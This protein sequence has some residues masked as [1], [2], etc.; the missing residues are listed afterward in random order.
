MIKEI[1]RRGLYGI[2]FGG[3]ATFIALTIIKFAH[4]EETAAEVWNH[5][6]A[7]FGLGIYF[8]LASYIFETEKWSPLRK[9]ITHY[10]LSIFVYI[11]IALPVGW[12]PFNF[13][14]VA[15]GILLFTVLYSLYW[16][17]FFI[18]YKRNVDSMNEQL[19][20]NR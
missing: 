16:T 5:M 6:L 10:T 8:G 20:K 3:I 19:G 18:Y 7:S 9:T 17:G 2:A 13:K 14:A 15:I 12:I 11:L 4:F 1:L